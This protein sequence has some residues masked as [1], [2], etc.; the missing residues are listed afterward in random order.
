MIAAVKW[1]LSVTHVIK[2]YHLLHHTIIVSL[3]HYRKLDLV[4]VM[5]HISYLQLFCNNV[6]RI[7]NDITEHICTLFLS[8]NYY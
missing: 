6:Y 2:K 5:L 7:I 3:Q 8:F 1:M 4:I